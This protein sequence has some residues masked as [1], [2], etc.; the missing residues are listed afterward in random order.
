MDEDKLQRIC[1]EAALKSKSRLSSFFCLRDVTQK[2]SLSHLPFKPCTQENCMR[3][4]P[5]KMIL[6]RP[7]RYALPASAKE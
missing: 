5:R 7:S 3:H 2:A 4:L 6:L 1:E